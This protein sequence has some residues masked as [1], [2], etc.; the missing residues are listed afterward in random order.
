[1]GLL[2]FSTGTKSEKLKLFSSNILNLPL[3][4]VQSPQEIEGKDS[5]N[6]FL[7]ISIGP[8]TLFLDLQLHLV[9]DTPFKKI[10]FKTKL[11]R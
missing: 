10:L 6:V 11:L 3:V 5:K 7:G 2:G 1:V 9:P 4:P 8:N